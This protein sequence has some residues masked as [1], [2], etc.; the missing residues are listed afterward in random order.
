MGPPTGGGQRPPSRLWPS[1]LVVA[2]L[3]AGAGCERGAQRPQVPTTSS[4]ERAALRDELLEMQRADQLERTGDPSLPPGTRL[5]PPQ[6]YVRALRLAAIVDEHGWPTHDLV[7]ERAAS[8]AWLVAQHAD[9]DPAFQ[10]RALELLTAAAAAGQADPTEAA[11]LADR[12]AVNEGQAQVY[13]SQVRC[14]AGAPA[15]ATPLVDP[16]SVDARRARVGM[17]P[18]ADYYASLALLCSDEAADG[19]TLGGG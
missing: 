14:T 4:E 18:L 1:L 3:T 15:P 11:Y 6:D 12:V 9:V 17:E 13:G 8:A 16:R 7:G 5:P 19:A 2:L 10:R